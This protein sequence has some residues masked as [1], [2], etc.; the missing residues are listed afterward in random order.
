MTKTFNNYEIEEITA[1]AACNL[2]DENPEESRQDAL[3]VTIVNNEAGIKD[4]FVV[5]GFEMPEDEEDFENIC[6][7][8]GAWESYDKVIATA[9]RK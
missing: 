8:S 4:E 7:D 9:K 3:L 5:F 2:D 6:E 1:I